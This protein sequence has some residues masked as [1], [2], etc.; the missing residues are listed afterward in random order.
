MDFYASGDR[1]NVQ[2]LT[3]GTHTGQRSIKIT[4]ANTVRPD[5]NIESTPLLVLEKGK[6]YQISAHVRTDQQASFSI[7]M[8]WYEDDGVTRTFAASKEYKNFV[9]PEWTRISHTSDTSQSSIYKD[10]SIGYIYVHN[11][12]QTGVDPSEVKEFTL[13]VDDIS[14]RE[15]IE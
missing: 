12:T 8:A 4:S 5:P 15:I 10:A 9:S 6:R 2:L 11:H 13:Y 3:G 7:D 1:Q 14:L